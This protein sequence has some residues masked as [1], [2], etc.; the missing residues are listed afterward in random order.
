ML[1]YSYLVLRLD[2]NNLIVHF[3]PTTNL[4]DNKN[5]FIKKFNDDWILLLNTL[6]DRNINFGNFSMI[7][8]ILI[9]LHSKSYNRWITV[10]YGVYSA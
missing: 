1:Y 3:I 7:Q 4:D 6:Q 2:S 8:I 5:I 9:M 10:S